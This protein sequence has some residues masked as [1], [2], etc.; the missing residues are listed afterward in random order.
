MYT[1]GLPL[2]NK[3]FIGGGWTAQMDFTAESERGFADALDLNPHLKLV[4]EAQRTVVIER[5][6]DPWP[7]AVRPRRVDRGAEGS[8]HG[9]FSG[10]KIAKEFTEVYDP[11]E[12]GLMEFHPFFDDKMR[13]DERA[14]KFE[15]G[16][17]PSTREALA[18]IN[19]FS[20]RPA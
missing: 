16:W 7:A 6:G 10:L 11:S 1:R 14:N 8:K 19:A 2:G 15:I 12:I 9:V 5:A 3:T 17:Q 20:P 4:L 18:R 13:H